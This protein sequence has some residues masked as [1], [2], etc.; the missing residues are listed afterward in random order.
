[1]LLGIDF[2]NT[3]VCYDQVFH[4]I[5]QEQG[6]IPETVPVNKGRRSAISAT[7]EPRKRVD[8]NA[9]VTSTVPGSAK[10][11]PFP[12][13]LRITSGKPLKRQVMVCII[14]HKT[15][16]PLQ[17]APARFAPQAAYRLAR[18]ARIFSTRQRLDCPRENVYLELTKSAK[19]ERIAHVR[20]HAFRRRPAGTAGRTRLPGRS[21]PMGLFDPAGAPRRIRPVRLRGRLAYRQPDCF[22]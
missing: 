12:G 1:M 3:I 14:S 5:A 19:L 6:L 16:H 8:R 4:R 11:E 9:R 22:M 21:D 20:L 17:G 2:D 13:V 10:P 18:S 15:R 7:S